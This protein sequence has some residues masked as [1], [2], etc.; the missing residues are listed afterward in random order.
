MAV[1]PTRTTAAELARP[2]TEP[3]LA[4]VARLRQLAATELAGLRGG[5]V[6]LAEAA[7]GGENERAAAAALD[8]PEQAVWLGTLDGVAVGY[9]IA[10]VDLLTDGRRLVVITDVFVEPSARGVG[11]GEAIMVEV[12][13]WAED[14]GAAGVDAWALPGARETK[15]FF[16]EQG[17]SARLLTMHHRLRPARPE[18]VGSTPN[19]EP[20][21]R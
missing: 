21:P 2:A 1:T 19:H 13:A 12:L 10:R 3:D 8:D 20:A 18:E 14:R 7:R 4:E 5:P 17:F 16:E 6:F 9:A 11:V 15:N